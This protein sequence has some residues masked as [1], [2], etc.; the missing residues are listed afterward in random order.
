MSPLPP[1]PARHPGPPDHGP[2]LLTRRLRHLGKALSATHRAN[3]NSVRADPG[4]LW[5]GKRSPRLG[6]WEAP[7]EVEESRQEA[8]VLSCSPGTK[9]RP[10]WRANHAAAQS[11]ADPEGRRKDG[12]P[13]RETMGQVKVPHVG[14]HFVEQLEEGKRGATGAQAALL[15]AAPPDTGAFCPRCSQHMGIQAIIPGGFGGIRAPLRGSQSEAGCQ[16]TAIQEGSSCPRTLAP[17][18]GSGRLRESQTPW[19]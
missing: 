11:W 14:S 2:L 16:S 3:L 7:S 9:S 19:P 18:T 13:P 8:Q 1:L 17:G 15:A 6:S 4:P 12:G 10:G 5:L